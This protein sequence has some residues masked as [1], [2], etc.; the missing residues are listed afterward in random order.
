MTVDNK[1]TG[2]IN[3]IWGGQIIATEDGRKGSTTVGLYGLDV[4]AN[5]NSTATN[6]ITSIFGLRSTINTANTK[7]ATNMYGGNFSIYSSNQNPATATK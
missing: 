3:S 2:T 4:R 7:N 6:K 5:V 1:G